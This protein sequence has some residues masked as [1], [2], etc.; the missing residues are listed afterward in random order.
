MVKS[1]YKLTNLRFQ[2]ILNSCWASPNLRY[3][4]LVVFTI[5]QLTKVQRD[6]EEKE[7]AKKKDFYLVGSDF[8]IRKK[9]GK[10]VL[11]HQTV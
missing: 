11:K 9:K 3:I 4:L 8:D 1:T 5:R 2:S 7:K 6:M 10:K